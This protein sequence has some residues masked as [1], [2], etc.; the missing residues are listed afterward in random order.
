[1]G[2]WVF[3]IVFLV[4]LIILAIIFKVKIHLKSFFK[5]GYWARRGPYGTRVYSGPQ[6][7]GKTT[8]LAT[9]IYDNRDKI[10][11]FS[12]V[13]FNEP[14]KSIF[15]NGFEE[16]IEI[17]KGL[18]DGI[19]EI[20]K[21]QI[22]IVFD[23]LF[24]ELTKGSKL[25]TEVLDFLCQLRKR[26]ILFLTTCQSWPDLPLQFRRLARYNIKCKMLSI[27]FVTSFQWLEVQD[28]ENMHWDEIQQDFVAPTCWTDL[29]HTR[30]IIGTI[31]DTNQRITKDT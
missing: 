12:N 1:M 26:K 9:F 7:C 31:F 6:G 13:K 14:I 3:V 20:G 15:F 27:P 5:K 2:Y 23:E 29:Y 28:A 18:D 22:V 19:Y 21:K 10:F 8:A 25:N 30:K 24:T 17:K 11:L 4:L 16:L